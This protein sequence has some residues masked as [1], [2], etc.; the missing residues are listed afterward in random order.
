M[1]GT[2]RLYELRARYV[3]LAGLGAG[4]MAPM[5]AWMFASMDLSAG[6]IG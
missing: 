3:L 6:G 2:I 5:R 1:L 4:P